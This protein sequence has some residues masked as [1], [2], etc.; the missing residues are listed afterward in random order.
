M[1]LEKR[2]GYLSKGMK[3]KLLLIISLSPHPKLLLFDEPISDL[4]PKA[5][6]DVVEEL[7]RAKE[8]WAPAI[9]FSSHNISELSELSEKV[10]FIDQGQIIQNDRKINL[11]SKWK[12][13]HIIDDKILNFSG[14]NDIIHSRYLRGNTREIIVNNYS[15]KIIKEIREKSRARIDVFDMNL[16][17]IFLE[18]IKEK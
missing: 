5:K 6:Y 14:F 18:S 16:E 17:Q 7:I 15:D 4:D 12:K 1:P 2:F 8:E 11:L 13:I 9:F 3:K 10:I